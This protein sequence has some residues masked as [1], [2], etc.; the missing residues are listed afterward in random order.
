M[1]SDDSYVCKGA[2]YSVS[3]NPHT[4]TVRSKGWRHEFERQIPL[5][6]VRSVV[7]ERKSL[8]PVASSAILAGIIGVVVKFNALWF[9][10]DLNAN[11]SGRLSIIAFLV[12]ALLAIPSFERVF[13][14]NIVISSL[15]AETFRVRFVAS[16]A[17]KTLT[18]RFL[19]FSSGA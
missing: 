8:V 2:N 13:F 1:S 4:L 16:N 7:V 18:A 9:I 19:E 11:I 12:A 5:G 15:N 17:G 14:V 6:D 10:F 3:M